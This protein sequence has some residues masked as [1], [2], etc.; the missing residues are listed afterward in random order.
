MGEP[1]DIE[2]NKNNDQIFLQL[3]PIYFVD[4]FWKFTLGSKWI[5][6]GSFKTQHIEYG[7]WDSC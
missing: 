3:P 6:F 2:K 1:M 7:S 4:V 5:K